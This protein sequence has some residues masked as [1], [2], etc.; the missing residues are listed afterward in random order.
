[1]IKMANRKITVSNNPKLSLMGTPTAHPSITSIG[2]MNSSVSNTLVMMERIAKSS[3]LICSGSGLASDL[4]CRAIVTAF[5]KLPACGNT[6]I[7][8]KDS[9]IANVLDA[10]DNLETR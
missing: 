8:A 1:M 3:L 2:K 5:V 4:V 6:T 10:T 9:G 7:A